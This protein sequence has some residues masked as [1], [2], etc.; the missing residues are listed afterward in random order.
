MSGPVG[1]DVVGRVGVITL[2]RPEVRNAVDSAVA[3]GIEAAV[4]RLESDASLRA[5][6]LAAEG[7]VFCSG[8]DLRVIAAGSAAS[9][10][11][12]RGGFGGL[13]WRE[14]SK[15]LVAAVDGPAVAGGFE[16]ALACDMV[17]ASSAAWF[18]L[19]E[20]Q[21][22]LVAAAGGLF[23][24]PR[25]LPRNIALELAVTGRRLSAERALHFGV[26]NELV[27]PGAALSAAVRLADEVAAAAPVAVR[28]SR[29]VVLA[30]ASVDDTEAWRLTVEARTRNE[31]TEDYKEGPRAFLE[32]RPPDWLGR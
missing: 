26:V 18:S 14:R 30:G 8:A 2:R 32:K 6:V 25:A 27:E 7:P 11:T 22:G 19:P 10:R 1:F 4:D 3:A 21:R 17:V 16:L 12:E 5:G 23:R 28:E 9:F 13:V 31:A 29:A 24:L 15:V 20:V